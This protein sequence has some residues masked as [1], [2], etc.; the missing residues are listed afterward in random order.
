MRIGDTISDIDWSSQTISNRRESL[1][2]NEVY[3]FLV[4]MN[5]GQ[6]ANI[7]EIYIYE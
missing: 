6:K 2:P 4:S 1:Y 5:K 3:L 7:F